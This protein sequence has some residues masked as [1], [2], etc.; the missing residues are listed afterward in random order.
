M[1]VFHRYGYHPLLHVQS[2]LRLPIGVVYSITTFASGAGIALGGCF[3][4]AA[5]KGDGSLCELSIR[6][7]VALIKQSPKVLHHML[8]PDLHHW[9]NVPASFVFT[10]APNLMDEPCFTSLSNQE[11]G[12]ATTFLGR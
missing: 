11:Q 2:W 6:G 4:D 12:N 9:D 3:V 5:A 8:S 1:I 7:G 10:T